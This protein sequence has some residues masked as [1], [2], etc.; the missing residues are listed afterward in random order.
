MTTQATA[1]PKPENKPYEP[2]GAARDLFY[3][4]ADEILIEGPTGTGKTRAILEKVFLLCDKY[5]GCRILFLRNTRASMTDS[6]LVTW[7][8][9]VVPTNHDILVGPHRQNRRAYTFGN[10]SEVV[11]GGL[12]KPGKIFS[13]DYDMGIVFEA[14][15]ITEDI[16]EKLQTRLRY[17]VIPYQQAVADCNPDR[18]THW[19]NLRAATPR[20]TRLLS[21]HSDNPS[22]TPEYLRKLD[23]LT[24]VRRARYRDG[25]WAAAEGMVYDGFD[26]SVHIVPR[27]DVPAEWR[28]IRVVDFGYTN[29]FVCQW[30]AVDN[31]GRIFLYRELYQTRTLVADHAHRISALSG[32]EH[33]EATIAD[34]DAEDRATLAR[35]GIQTI[36]AYK[37]VTTGIEAVQAR[38]RVQDDGKPRLFVMADALV[39]RD[40]ELAEAK[41]PLC[42]EQEFPGYVW[43]KGVDGKSQKEQ[44]V[45][46]D[47]HGMD[48]MRYAVAYVDQINTQ[49]LDV[50]VIGPGKEDFDEERHWR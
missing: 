18:P 31:D 33:I 2:F 14:I 34:H 10:G 44:P 1:P 29:P 9:K 50:R 42:T 32:D 8:E 24:G 46:V 13:T 27:F 12:D 5:P 40:D 35:E 6:V 20:M 48:A 21:R 36:G 22:V 26:A 30:W 43:P 49:P 15:E 3:C 23:N 17:H 45:K 39:E 4:K 7:E 47:D 16:W 37:A 19:L 25:I 28:R 38:I 11:L 41:K